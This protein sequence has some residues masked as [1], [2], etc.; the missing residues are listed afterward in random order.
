MSFN[1]QVRLPAFL[2]FSA[3]L[4]LAACG[5]EDQQA[6]AQQQSAPPPPVTVAQALQQ[7]VTEW[8][9]YTGRFEAK[10]S[11]DVKARVSGYL[12]S[13]HFQEGQVV[14][15]GD[16]LFVIDPRPFEIELKSARAAVDQATAQLELAKS[17]LA[18]AASLI[19]NRNIPERELEARRAAELQAVANLSAAEARL[20]QAELD[21][22]WTRVPAPITGRIS[23]V[24][25]DVGNLITGGPQGATLLTTI[26]SLDPITFVFEVS[27]ADHIKYMRQAEDGSR[28]TARQSPLP[29]KVK[30]LDESDYDLE[31]KM[32]FVDNQLDFNS[33]TIRSRAIF[34]NKQGFITPGI[35]GRLRLYAGEGDALLLP[36]SAILAD[37]AQR[38]VLVVD[39][40]GMVN[41]R[42]VT[43]GPLIDGLRVIRSGISAEDRVIIDGLLRARPGQQVTPESGKI[44]AAAAPNQ[45]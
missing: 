17:D 1:G 36:D 21:L 12:E 38:I 20:Q 31:G 3:L 22:E 16:L 32:D 7:R 39:G 33:G 4:F 14:Q 45:G 41:R 10:E 27:E 11:V 29:V 26:V 43:L 34:D 40:E 44:V 35:F 18:R 6:Q 2:A 25:T 42:V 37:Q 19:A 23:N 9:E 15:K 8:D 13:V 5:P 24:R 28:P 30:L